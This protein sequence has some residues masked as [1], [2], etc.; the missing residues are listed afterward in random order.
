MAIIPALNEAEALPLVLAEIPRGLVHEVIVV[1]N[2]STDGTAEVASARGA[3][4]VREERRG[5]G[6]ACLRGIAAAGDA[7]V[8]VFLDGDH[9][10]HPE[11]LERLLPPVLSGKA[12]LAIGTRM[13]TPESRRALLPQARWGNRLATLLMRLLF[14][15]RATDLGPFRAISAAALRRLGMRD[16]DYGW[17]IE[18]QLRAHF[19]GLRVVEVPVR[20]RT[21]IGRSK[22][23][24]TLRGSLGAA[25]K[26]L[27][28]ILRY[29]LR[30]PRLPGAG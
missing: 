23:T 20:Y 29:R 19:A 5:Y 4:V 22:I 26:I 17:T 28:T 30:P 9:S 11:D 10:D 13:A 24:G 12:D 6:S 27:G 1:D 15:V 18:M 21:R 16:P 7:D 14:G 8:I 3:R 2:G 25:R